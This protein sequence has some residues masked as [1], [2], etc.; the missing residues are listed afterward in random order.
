MELIEK[1]ENLIIPVTRKHDVF[2]IDIS[3]RGEGGRKVL[4]IFIDNKNGITTEICADI[5]N[6]LS[7]IL[8]EENT[9]KGNYNLNVSSPGLDRPLKYIEQYYKHIG[10][11]LEIRYHDEIGILTNTEGLLT[12]IKENL[13]SLKNDDKTD[14]VI[15]FKKI[16]KAIVKTPW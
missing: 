9:L 3:Y 2:L 14:F 5:S 8:D 11:P 16:N 4:E 12:E 6:E 10:H 1:L 7:K 13:I 15:E